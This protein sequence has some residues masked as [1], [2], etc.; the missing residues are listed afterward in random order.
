M[1]PLTCPHNGLLGHVVFRILESIEDFVS[2]VT[3]GLFLD[4]KT[5]C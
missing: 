1:Y 5:K 3:T 4:R 2:L